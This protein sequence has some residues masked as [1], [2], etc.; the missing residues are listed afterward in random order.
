MWEKDVDEKHTE[1]LW[2]EFDLFLNPCTDLDRDS[3]AP[4]SQI[5]KQSP[6][7][8]GNV[9]SPTHRATFTAPGNTPGTKFY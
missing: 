9:V 5:S 7:E 2:H 6:H 3:G 1:I 4:S 8:G